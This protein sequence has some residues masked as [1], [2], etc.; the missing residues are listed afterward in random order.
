MKIILKPGTTFECTPTLRYLVRL[1]MANDAMASGLCWYEHVS[2]RTDP[3]KC[4]DRYWSL[5]SAG[6]RAAVGIRL[7]QDGVK[8]RNGFISRK[9]LANEAK[10]PGC[11]TECPDKVTNVLTVWDGILAKPS[12]E[13][14]KLMFV[15]RNTFWAH[16]EDD[17]DK[18]ARAFLE[19]EGG[20]G[21]VEEPHTTFSCCDEDGTML[22]SWYPWEI[23]TI[24]GRFF[25]GKTADQVCDMMSEVKSTIA[26]VVNITALLI[27]AL[28]EK[29][30]L[31]FDVTGSTHS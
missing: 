25:R 27:S 16:W 19:E 21:S 24:T 9:M 20:K 23:E 5:I 14:I 29:A 12:P 22:G 3:N 2:R 15:F 6:G 30:G 11:A 8:V 18:A 10:G 17:T 26:G 13:P 1:M 31:E 28:A 7:L 4:R